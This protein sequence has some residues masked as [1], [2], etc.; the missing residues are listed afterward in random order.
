MSNPT[1]R[2]VKLRQDLQRSPQQHQGKSYLV[3]KDPVA[4]RYFR[5]TE[6]QAAIV[7]SIIEPAD[8]ETVAARLS[9]KLGGRV[10][11]ATIAAFFASLESKDLLDTPEVRERLGTLEGTNKRSSVLYK[12]VASFNPERIFNWLL[13]R[14]RWA[15]TPAF[16]IFGCALIVSGLAIFLLN[17]PQLRASTPNLLNVWTVLMVW[18]I[19]FSVS[20]YHEFSHGLTC[21]HFGGQVKEVGFMLIYFS[22]AFYCDVSDAWMFP[23]RRHRMFVTLAGGYAQLMLWGLCAIIWRVTEP[24]TYINHIMLVVVLFSGLQTLFNFNPLIKLDGYYMLSD[25]LEIPNLRSKAFSS[26]WN[27]IS[28]SPKRKSFREER[29]Q[30]I[31]GACAV[32]F[33][34]SLLIA[35]Y[36]QIFTWA[37][38]KWATAGL[39]GFAVFSTL[40][41]RRT[42]IESMAGLKTIVSHVAVKKFRNAFIAGTALLI[43]IFVPWELKIPAEFK[44]TGGQG[45]TWVNA[46]T[47]GILTE[48]FAREGVRV[49]R[50][51]VLART[52]DY[53]KKNEIE[54]VSGELQERQKTLEKL[55]APPRPQEI[56]QLETRIAEKKVE[57]ANARRTE[58]ERARLSEI[59]NQ[60]KTRLEFLLVDAENYRKGVLEGVFA[61]RLAQEAQNAVEVQQHLIAEGEATIRSFNEG[62]DGTEA[63]LKKELESLESDLRLLKA[64]N[65][66][67]AID[68]AQ[69]QVQSRLNLLA[70]LNAEILKSE[71][72]A[73]ID[74]T[75]VTSRPEQMMRRKLAAGEPFVR[76]VNL[77]TLQAEL[78]VPEKELEDV[79]A[80][81]VVWLYVRGLP[82]ES[83][84]ARVDFIAPVAEVVDGQ[85]MFTVRSENL[86]KND[87]L[88]PGMTG[89]ARIYAGKRPIISV[90]TRRMQRWIK[91]EFLSLLP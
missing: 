25:Y 62:A 59:V 53:L 36:S 49:H 83:F 24:D 10:S 68:E 51:E 17:W 81:S 70:S 78:M 85:R 1:P 26:L 67:E 69:A 48:I 14:T 80:G 27:W 12:Q 65:R 72:R 47:A 76:L 40:T 64:G 2:Q 13:P 22:P 54:R 32:I 8:A 3:V 66:K 4:R 60:R 20:A 7:E 87:L 86:E 89:I 42:A 43:T 23:E 52:E 28:K 34:T 15:F 9:E 21:R 50:G 84:Q 33:S 39:V 31:Y 75:V 16:Q 71:I 45:E 41:L 58:Q 77:D 6:T 90:A 79:K 44:I 19:V 38:G 56:E 5:F 55:Q 57:L 11:S 63:L 73:P 46:E 88:K 37:T 74:G 91:T 29:A 35:V 61:A 30:L 18:P 82:N